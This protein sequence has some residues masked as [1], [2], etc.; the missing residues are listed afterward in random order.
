MPREI[1]HVISELGNHV[2]YI[3]HTAKHVPNLGVCAIINIEGEN[4]SLEWWGVDEDCIEA[5]SIL[6]KTYNDH[7]Y[8]FNQEH[9]GLPTHVSVIEFK[10]KKQQTSTTQ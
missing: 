6:F 4:L 9:L 7:S 8:V 3:M 1:K 5:L 2:L 10:N